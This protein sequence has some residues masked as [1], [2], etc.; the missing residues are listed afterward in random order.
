MDHL[1]GDGPLVLH[2]PSHGDRLVQHPYSIH[3]V[4]SE[5]LGVTEL[6][7]L[8]LGAQQFGFCVWINVGQQVMEVIHRGQGE[9]RQ[10]ERQ[11]PVLKKKK[12]KTL[13]K[14]CIKT[15]YK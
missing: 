11:Q 13:L 9:L 3:L 12:K 4:Y 15:T 5:G 6:A 14:N 7:E 10:R 1:R 2:I 8:S